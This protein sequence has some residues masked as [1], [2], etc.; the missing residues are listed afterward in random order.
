MGPTTAGLDSFQK[1]KISGSFHPAPSLGYPAYTLITTKNTLTQF[2]LIPLCTHTVCYWICALCCSL[3]FTPLHQRFRKIYNTVQCQYGQWSEGPQ[4]FQQLDNHEWP[5]SVGYTGQ[6][7]EMS[8]YIPSLKFTRDTNLEGVH[9][10]LWVEATDTGLEDRRHQRFLCYCHHHTSIA[11]HLL[12]CRGIHYALI[13]Y[14]LMLIHTIT[15][16]HPSAY[17]RNPT[18][19]GYVSM[20]LSHNNTST[21]YKQRKIKSWNT[22]TGSNFSHPFGLSFHPITL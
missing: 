5:L 14:L 8:K 2:L 3:E 6:V 21:V 10:C 7:R 20:S 1:R 18:A 12:L 17:K 15:F 13:A 19:S 9:K 4:R 11:A 22:T 16:D